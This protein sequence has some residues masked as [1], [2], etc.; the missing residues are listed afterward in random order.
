MDNV[1][2][3]LLAAIADCQGTIRA[4]DTKIN[5]LV[6]ILIIPLTKLGSIERTCV[7]LLSGVGASH[8][9]MVG[10]VLVFCAA[11]LAAAYFAY[12]GLVAIDNPE[13]HINSNGGTGVFYSGDLFE[14]KFLD[15]LLNRNIT[16][17]R[18][19]AG[20]VD[21]LPSNDTLIIKELAFEQMK[22]GYIRA[23]KLKRARAAYN[24]CAVWV[25]TGGAIWLLDLMGPLPK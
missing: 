21:L 8:Y 4:L 17:E 7:R 25:C 10:L 6:V 18:S 16:S 24:A 14:V 22:V 15:R 5:Y 11:W 9:V 23:I 3:F 1:I 13:G 20:Q 12:F 19:L 2:K